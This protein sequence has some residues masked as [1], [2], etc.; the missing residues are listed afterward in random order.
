MRYIILTCRIM[1]LLI[2]SSSELHT[3]RRIAVV[4]VTGRHAATSNTAPLS[5]SLNLFS[6]LK[7]KECCSV[8]TKD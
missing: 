5:H 7:F 3:D 4:A 6:R 1:Y 8:E 2:S